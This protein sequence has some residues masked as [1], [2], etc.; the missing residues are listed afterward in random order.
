VA[1]TNTYFFRGEVHQGMDLEIAG[2]TALVAASSSGL[3]KASAAA[4]AAEG[5]NVVVN[6]R[7]PDRL[8]RTA[9]ELRESAAGEVYP[10]AADLTDPAAVEALVETTVAEFGGIDHLVTNA[11]GPPS[12]PFLGTTGDDWQDAYELLVR[13]AEG[14]CRAASEPLRADGGGTIVSITSK[15]VKE[16][17]DGL[18]LSNSVR[19]AVVGLAKTL[20]SE[21]APEVRANVVMPGSHATE[22]MEELARQAHERGDYESV[23]AARESFVEGVPAG[24]MGD[25]ERFGQVVAFLSGEP[26]SFVNGAALMV[27]GGEAGSIL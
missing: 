6:G 22:R 25:P 11:G 19:M 3:G 8:E 13:S 14:L 21:W 1:D 10:V 5:A 16:A 18:V 27:D 17:V 15:S 20:S 2:N 12:G 4:L 9:A 24:R 23:A 26:T 7:D